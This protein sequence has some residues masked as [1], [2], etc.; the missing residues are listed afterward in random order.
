MAEA[1]GS[2]PHVTFRGPA[3]KKLHAPTKTAITTKVDTEL[4]EQIREFCHVNGITFASFV[5]VALAEELR[6]QVENE[7]TTGR[8]D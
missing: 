2:I 1:S 8:S 5:E 3:F 4:L 6:K 7:G